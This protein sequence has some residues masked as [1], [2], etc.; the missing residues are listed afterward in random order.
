M[1]YGGKCKTA[2]GRSLYHRLLPLD[3][4]FAALIYD[5]IL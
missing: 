4:P 2:E 1:K 5:T 3:L